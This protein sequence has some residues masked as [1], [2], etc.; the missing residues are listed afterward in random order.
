MTNANETSTF[1]PPAWMGR[2]EK[3]L[4]NRVQKLRNARNSP[5]NEAELP[6]LI[7]Y[8][9][10]ISRI[11]VLDA[12][13]GED[14]RRMRSNRNDVVARTRLMAAARQIDA[15]TKLAQGMW[16]RLMGQDGRATG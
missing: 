9:R 8:V 6:L 16:E 15:S 14:D 5:L 4:F 7:D 2:R 1:R 3:Q 13:F 12:A 11:E 10:T